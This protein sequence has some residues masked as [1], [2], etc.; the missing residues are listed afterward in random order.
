M[1]TRVVG[2]VFEDDHTMTCP[3][4]PHWDS[5]WMRMAK[6]IS[7]RSVDP[8]YKIGCVIVTIDNDQVL[9]LGYNAM[10]KGGANCVDSLDRGQSGTL[11]AE[12][13]ALIKL[14]FN[15][16]KRKKLYVSLS[17]CKQCARA[18]IN[19]NINEVIYDEEYRD[20]SGIDLLIERGIYVRQYSTT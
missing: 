14:D 10:E 18:I 15:N 3:E 9:S 20:R 7:L 17:P 2:V 19:A 1:F 13:N 5:I 12:I 11:H 6:L 8:A 4:R 16:P